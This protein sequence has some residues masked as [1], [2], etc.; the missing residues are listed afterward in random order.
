MEISR[1]QA[2]T[3]GAAGVAASAVTSRAGRAAPFDGADAALIPPATPGLSYLTISR[4]DFFPDDSTMGR[5]I[6]PSGVGV[7]ST[8]IPINFFSA[9][10]QLPV[11]AII[12]EVT[13]WMLL[14]TASAAVFG[15][16]QLVLAV[17]DGGLFNVESTFNF[18]A[19]PAIQTQ[20]RALNRV[21]SRGEA[22]ILRAQLV[23]GETARIVGAMIGYVGSPLFVPIV[24]VRAYDSRLDMSPDANGPLTSG[25]N[26]TTSIANSRDLVTGAVTTPNAVPAGAHAVAYNLAIVNMRGDG[27]LT[28]TPGGTATLSTASINWGAGTSGA[29]SNAGIVAIDADRKVKTFAGGTPGSRTDYVV[30]IAGYYV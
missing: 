3:M 22:Y 5:T 21:V 11:G 12:R 8:S 13:F 20:T 19:S 10:V 29:L 2:I 16:P 6:H 4:Y 23:A 18:S 14:T 7:H 26:R 27:F 17:P 9:S 15:N 1:R 25:S 30:D 24:P 28:M